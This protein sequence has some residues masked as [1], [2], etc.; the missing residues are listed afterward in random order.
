MNPKDIYRQQLRRETVRLGWSSIRAL[1][2]ER[3]A[4]GVALE[5]SAHADCAANLAS[6]VPGSAIIGVV[7]TEN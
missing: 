3:G 7:R 1:H 6:G 4:I 2:L 5:K